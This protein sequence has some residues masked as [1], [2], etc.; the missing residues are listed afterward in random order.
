MFT[1][2][3]PSARAISIEPSVEPLSATIT[4]PAM[5]RLSKGGHCLAHAYA[6]GLPLIQAGHDDRHLNLSFGGCQRFQLLVK[7]SE[8]VIPRSSLI[9]ELILNSPVKA[10]GIDIDYLNTTSSAHRAPPKSLLV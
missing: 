5:P 4:S 8:E 7:T 1:T 10:D 3:A 6:N 2:R 9:A